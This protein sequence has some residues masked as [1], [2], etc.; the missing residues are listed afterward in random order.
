M[1]AGAGEDPPPP[2]ALHRR[3]G[4]SVMKD[5]DGDLVVHRSYDGNGNGTPELGVNQLDQGSGR[6]GAY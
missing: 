2:A 4:Q 3:G 6:P 1:T 5:V